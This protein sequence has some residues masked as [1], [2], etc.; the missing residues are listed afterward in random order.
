MVH[1][2]TE[3]STLTNRV[4][5]YVF[6]VLLVVYF[7]FVSYVIINME[8]QYLSC[9]KEEVRT[10]IAVLNFQNVSSTEIHQKITKVLDSYVM[11]RK[12]VSV[13]QNLI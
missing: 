10:I 5:K 11:S 13:V 7:N 1:I 4:V 9:I 3:F 6:Y 8:N 2:R 12:S